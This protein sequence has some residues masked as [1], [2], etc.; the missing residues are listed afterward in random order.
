MVAYVIRRLIQLFFVLILVSVIVFL[1]MRLLPGDPLLLYKVQNQLEQLS[2]QALDA[3]RS[4]YGLDK[5]IPLQYFDWIRG[6]SHG[7]FG[8]SI[9]FNADVGNLLRERLPI[10]AYLGILALIISTILGVLAGLVCA[11]RRGGWVD[12]IVTAV[13]NF[14]ISVPIF[15]LGVL[16]VYVFSLYLGW[17][18]VQGF[19][20][21]FEDLYSSARQLIMP[22]IC[23]SVMALASNTRQ[24]RSSM[25]E[26]IRQDYIRTAWSKGLTERTI[27]IRHILKNGLIPVMTLIGMQVGHILGG[28][29]LI[30]T[31]FNIPG[32]GRLMVEAVINKDYA[33]VQGGILIIAVIVMLANLAVDISYGWLDPRIRYG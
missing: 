5:S 12:T 30:E 32:M 13:A 2:P 1:V 27:V 6:L 21:P 19:T 31:V 23:L 29:V 16:M 18:P 24:T 7:E 25:L 28:S 17:L 33:I 26:I 4:Q 8:R 3:L 9:F 10:T 15:W 22:V 14:G 20:S 11:L